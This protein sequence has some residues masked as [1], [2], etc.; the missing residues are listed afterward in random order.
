M[1]PGLWGDTLEIDP[2][3]GLG[4]GQDWD[5]DHFGDEWNGTTVPS[6]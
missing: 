2:V 1:Q 4:A 6:Q 3:G 5:D